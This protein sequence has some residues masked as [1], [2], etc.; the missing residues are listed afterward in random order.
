MPHIA[1]HDLYSNL[2]IVRDVWSLVRGYNIQLI[3]IVQ[4]MLQLQSL[5]KEE[6]EN[7]AAQAGMVAT[8]GPAGDAFSA[9]FFFKRSGNTTMLQ[10]G[11]NL[12]DGVNSGNGVNAGTG[13]S[14]S[15]VS[16]NEGNGQNFGRNTSGGINWSQIERRAFL[17]QDFMNYRPGFGRIWTPG[18]G[19][20][21]IP[22]FAPN[23]WKYRSAP[24]VRHVR[25][26]PL[27]TG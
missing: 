8:L 17:P 21:S 13:F 9:E 16:S 15:G 22:F 27:R 26:N 6:W 2:P 12:G 18:M 14:N 7:F 11:F 10:A 24:W 25:P 5:F 23:Y 3:P 20:A 19:T 1:G 4:S